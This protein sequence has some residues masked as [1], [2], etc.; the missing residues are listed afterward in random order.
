MSSVASAGLVQIP[1]NSHF[2]A[3]PGLLTNAS[4]MS[5]AV[6]TFVA[7]TG[8]A[9]VLTAN[10]SALGATGSFISTPWMATTLANGATAY[11]ALSSGAAL[12]KDMG[13]TIV[14]AGRTFRRV[15]LMNYITNT[16]QNGG[17][18]SGADSDALC[19]YIEVGFRA[20]AAAG[21]F[22]RGF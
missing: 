2:R 4:N 17:T 19:G 14:S 3:V 1:R 20:T 16:E 12:L 10:G 9:P 22:V 21:P 15:Q 6:Y 7:T 18:Y 11:A 5:T 13:E 8:V